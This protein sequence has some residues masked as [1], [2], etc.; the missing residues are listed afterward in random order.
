MDTHHHDPPDLSQF[1]PHKL[2]F[3]VEE[4]LARVEVAVATLPPSLHAALYAE[5][6]RSVF[7]HVLVAIVA[8]RTPDAAAKPALENLFRWAGTAERIERLK[9]HQIE[10]LIEAVP[11]ARAKAERVKEIASIVCT[12]YGGDLPGRERILRSLPGVGVTCA[13]LVLGLCCDQDKLCVGAHVARVTKRWG[14]VTA[15]ST[16]GIESQLKEI[17]PRELWR[18]MGDWLVVFGHHVC[19][20]DNPRCDTCPVLAYCRQVGVST[21]S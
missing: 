3:N 8:A 13:A 16:S 18:F 5:G 4:V 19:R 7:Q 10:A 11:Y 17:I 20:K 14:V 6:F 9:L 12:K 21:I 15:T 2:R 1:T